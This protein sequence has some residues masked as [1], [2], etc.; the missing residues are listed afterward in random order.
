MIILMAAGRDEGRP[1]EY[2]RK[3][4]VFIGAAGAR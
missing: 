1:L 2:I 4:Y 3:F